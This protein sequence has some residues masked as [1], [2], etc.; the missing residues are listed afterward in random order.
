MATYLAKSTDSLIFNLTHDDKLIGKLTYK[1]WFKFNALVEMA[2]GKF[3]QV[4]PKGFWGTTIEV[5]ENEQVLAKFCM[6][7]NSEIVIRTFT[8]D[9]EKGYILTHKGVFKESFVLV[10]Q[11]GQELLIIKPHLEWFKMSSEYQIIT[12]DE[13]ENVQNKGTLLMTALQG[14]NYYMSLASSG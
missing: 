14:A 13:L 10:D 11:D 9:V 2:D 12:T 6:N 8:E 4:E 7:W 5:K 1:S 3:Y